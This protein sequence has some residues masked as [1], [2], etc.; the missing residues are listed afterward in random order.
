MD[1][2][3]SGNKGSRSFIHTGASSLLVIFVLVVLATFA[4][5]TLS[6]A[7]TDYTMAEDLSE[8]KSEYYEAANTAEQIVS[9]I[10]TAL[11]SA[12][13]S[14]ENETAY[15]DAAAQAISLINDSAEIALT[16]DSP[17]EVSFSLPIADRQNLEVS[18]TILYPGNTSQN[19]EQ[20]NDVFYRITKWTAVSASDWEGDDTVSIFDPAISLAG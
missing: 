6:T 2:N 16:M 3:A 18:L 9:S 19:G 13:T 14:S 7:H 8:R 1:Q 5:G 20:S 17:K 10:D 15:F 11:A 4:A 12:F